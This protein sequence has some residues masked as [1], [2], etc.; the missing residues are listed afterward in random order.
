MIMIKMLMILLLTA[1]S[2]SCKKQIICSEISRNSFKPMIFCDIAF[3][4]TERCRCRCFNMNTNT[5]IEDA[6]CSTEEVQFQSGNY[7]LEACDE[8][9]GPS[10]A[11]WALKV[12]PNLKRLNTIYNTYCK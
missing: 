5:T 3:K 8:I 6:L 7:P 12:S 11:D 2:I 1:C 9:G 10:K 4:P